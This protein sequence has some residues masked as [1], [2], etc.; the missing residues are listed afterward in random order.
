M[1]SFLILVR[2]ALVPV[3]KAFCSSVI[4]RFQDRRRM[5]IF[6]NEDEEGQRCLKGKRMQ[7]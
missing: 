5:V 3:K 7:D 4:F 2:F 1:L 6:D